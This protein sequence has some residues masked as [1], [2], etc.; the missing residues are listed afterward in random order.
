MATTLLTV[1]FGVK[2][3][4][5][6]DLNISSPFQLLPNTKAAVTSDENLY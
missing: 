3:S 5:I 2:T 1:K 4:D 6:H